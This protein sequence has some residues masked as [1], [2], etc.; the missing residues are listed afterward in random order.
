MQHKELPPPNE[1]LDAFMRRDA[2]YDGI[3]FTGVRTTGIFC[4]PSCPARKPQRQNVV[5]FRS[6][7]E[8]LF[9]GFRP[10]KR[11]RPT[12]RPGETPVEVAALLEELAEDPGRRLRDHDLRERGLDPVRIRRWFK[13][14]HQMTF[15]A[16]QRALR[17]G[18]ALREIADGRSVTEA[19]FESGYESLSGFDEAVRRIT[20]DA[21]SA[22]R[23]SMVVSLMRIDTPLGP[24]LGGT[25]EEAVC[26]LE[27]TDRR[28]LETQ[29]KRLRRHF[30]ANFLPGI[31]PIGRRLKEELEAYFA[32]DLR[33]FEVAVTMPGTPFQQQ[34][35]EALLT[36]PYGETRSYAQ[37]A[38][39]IGNP[40][41]VRAVARANGE[42]RIAII[43]P[44][45]RIIG[46]DGS[47]T[48]YGGG[49]WRKQWLLE[50]ELEYLDR[51]T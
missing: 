40:A 14:N 7:R 45:H 23:G 44:C 19:A 9:D 28:M 29:L 16:Y 21:P 36:V 38:A 20:G 10:C 25:T 31:N 22:T 39:A 34:V 11:C 46:S 13:R 32:G 49:V 17:L 26:L 4:L 15:Q 2:S 41:A 6:V 42:N 1:M 50:H 35:W 48:G 5:F 18:P 27:F 47:L 24:M 33:R 37:Q 12:R 3:F 43:I 8:A 51:G 30:K